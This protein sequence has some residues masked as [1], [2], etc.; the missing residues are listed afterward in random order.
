MS[1]FYDSTNIFAKIL[2]GEILCQKILETDHIL[3]FH[4]VNPKAKIHALVIPKGA[5]ISSHDFHKKAIDAEIV[6]YYRG[7]DE[8]LDL[9]GLSHGSG[10]RLVSNAGSDGGQEVPHFHMHILGGEKLPSF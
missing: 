10:Y 3:A 2:R 7:L 6:A 9:L 4:D 1:D 8:V 5:Y